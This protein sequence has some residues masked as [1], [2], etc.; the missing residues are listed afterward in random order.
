MN[1]IILI[2]SFIKILNIIKKIIIKSYSQVL[3]LILNIIISFIINYKMDFSS[4]KILFFIF[5]IVQK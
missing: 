4:I 1:I 3:L 5:Y 2:N